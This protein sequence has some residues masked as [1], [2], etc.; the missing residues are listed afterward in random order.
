[1]SRSRQPGAVMAD[2]GHFRFQRTGWGS[3]GFRVYG[4]Y[5]AVETMYAGDGQ[6]S[7]RDLVDRAEITRVTAVYSGSVT[8]SEEECG[9]R[10]VQK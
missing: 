8:T 6:D 7:A 2:P 5:A 3:T 4:R 9:R 10:Y 1:M